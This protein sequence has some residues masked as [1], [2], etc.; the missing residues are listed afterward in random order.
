MKK[1][2]KSLCIILSILMLFGVLTVAPITANAGMPTYFHPGI[3]DDSG[4]WYA[5]TWGDDSSGSWRTAYD[6]DGVITFY[7]LSKKVVFVL[8]DEQ[9][10]ELDD[11]S[12]GHTIHQSDD[13]DVNDTHFTATKWTKLNKDWNTYNFSGVWSDKEESIEETT[14]AQIEETT[15][16]QIEE[17]TAAPSQEASVPAEEPSEKPA[18]SQEASVPA[19]EPAETQAPSQEIT[20]PV[21]E[22]TEEQVKLENPVTVS[23]STQ[24]LKAAELKKSAKT[25]RPIAIYN[26]KGSV[27]VEKV[28]SGSSSAI[29]GMASVNSSSGAV[30]FRKG[31]Y[32]TGTYTLVLK[33]TAAGNTNYNEKSVTKKVKIIIRGKS[34]NTLKVTT[35][36]K[37]IK[38]GKLKKSKSSFKFLT[39]KN[40]KGK[41][42]VSKVKKGTTKSIYKKIKV[43]KK[44]GKITFK[45]G[46]YKKGNYKIKFKIKAAGNDNYNAKTVT[47]TVNFRIAKKYKKC[48]H[49]KG[50]GYVS[51][52]TC[53]GKGYVYTGTTLTL[54]MYGFAYRTIR[55]TRSCGACGGDGKL[56]CADCDGH[57]TI[58]K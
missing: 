42:K 47:V 34:E 22:P 55:L 52:P 5:W 57:R 12:W 53:G 1:F 13:L 7:G 51:C 32:K 10:D 21:K 49:C 26:A 20:V 19:E 17:T 36:S 2:K 4:Y 11:M 18:P 46:S 43:N 56:D 33:V 44:T 15:S 27:K 31:T 23:T 50:K 35:K 45:K 16:A 39:I 41:I 14:A 28:S 38:S 25:V 8:M 54:Y 3:V 6:E 40:A 30:T 37:D 29:Y 58:M 48:S 24:T 9:L